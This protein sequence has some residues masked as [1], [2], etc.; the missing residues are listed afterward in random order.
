MTKYKADKAIVKEMAASAARWKFI[1]NG[2]KPPKR[3]FIEGMK[4]PFENLYQS[5]K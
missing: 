5:V 1:Y 3:A 2:N 4:H